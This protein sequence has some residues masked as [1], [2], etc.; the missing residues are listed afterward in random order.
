MLSPVLCAFSGGVAPLAVGFVLGTC[1]LLRVM[2]KCWW[3]WFFFSADRAQDVGFFWR[4]WRWL[5]RGG[6]LGNSEDAEKP[7]K[8]YYE[9]SKW[10]REVEFIMVAILPSE[11][12]SQVQDLLL[13]DVTPLS[14]GLEIAGGV[15]T[16]L[17]ERNTTLPTKKG[18]DVHDAR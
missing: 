13:L 2:G 8:C 11:G 16:K 18:T 17:I 6:Q 15:M 4:C 3:T 1:T 12:S 10:L 5:W 14:M 9:P 7:N